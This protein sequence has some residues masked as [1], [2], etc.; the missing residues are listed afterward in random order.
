MKKST[1]KRTDAALLSPAAAEK[2]EYARALDSLTRY[3]ARRD[4]SK[5][6]LRTRLGRKYPTELV[7]RLLSDAED[8]GWLPPEDQLAQRL[9]LTLA[10][11]HKSRAYIEAQLRAKGL[12]VKD[13]G[14]ELENAR[15]L[16]ERKFG[17]GPLTSEDQERAYRFLKYRGFEDRVIQ[18][19]LNEER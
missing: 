19:V 3:L 11:R 15:H 4:H 10:R 1:T 13:G 7:D 2:S 9:A 5:S 16:V 14:P 12:P 18:Q 17:P 8:S 6:E